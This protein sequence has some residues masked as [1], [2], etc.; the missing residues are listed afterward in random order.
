MSLHPDFI[1]E[2][3]RAT[4]SDLRTDSV[5]RKLYSTDASIYQIM[6][7]GVF[8]PKTHDELQAAVELAAKYKIPVLPRGSGSSLA[9]QAVGDA[10]I[11]DLSRY[12]DKIVDIDPEARNATAEPGVIL[13]DLNR[14]AAKFGLGFGPDPASADRATMGGVIAN[15]ATGAHSIRYGMAADHLLSADVI[16]ADG[17]LTTLGEV[18]LERASQIAH[19]LPR[20]KDF[21]PSEGLKPL[22]HG[23]GLPPANLEATLYSAALYIRKQYNQQIRTRWPQIWRNTSGYRLNYLLPWS[24]SRPPQWDEERYPNLDPSTFNLAPLLAGSEGTL[25]IMQRMTVNLVPLQREKILVVMPFESIADAVD[26][27]PAILEKKPSAIELLPRILIDLARDVPAY[28]PLIDFVDDDASD[29]LVVEFAGENSAHLRRQAENLG[30]NLRVVTDKMQQSNIWKVRKVG[31]GILSTSTSPTRGVTFIEDCAVPVEKL[32]DYVRGMERV[33]KHHNTTGVFYAHASAGC[34]HMRPVLNLQSAQGRGELRE[35]AEAALSLMLSLGGAMTG[36]HGD[37]LSRSEFLEKIYGEEINDAFRVLKLAADPE[38][39][40]NPGKIVSPPPMDENLRYG[41]SYAAQP[42]TVKPVLDFSAQGGLVNAI[43]QCNGAGVCRKFDGTMCPS[44]QATREESHSTR[45]RA[46]MLR[47]FISQAM[48]LR[49]SSSAEAI[50]KTERETA[51]QKNARSDVQEAVANSLDLCLACKGCQSECPS[52]VDMAKLKYEFFNDYYKK[53]LRKLRDYL[54]GYIG[55][56]AKIGAPFGWLVNLVLGNQA[57]GGWAKKVLRVS[58]HRKLPEF[59]KTPHSSLITPHASLTTEN[60][61]LNTVIY[62]PDPFS[63]YFEPE[64]EEAAL[65]VLRAAD[66]HVIKLPILGA[67]RTLISKS[68][69][70]AAKKHASKV[71]DEIAKVDPE[72]RYPVL[73]VEPSEIYT[74]KDEY[75]SFF[76]SDEKMKALAKRSWL[77][78]EFLLREKNDGENYLLRVAR[79]TRKEKEQNLANE[80]A[81]HNANAKSAQSVDKNERTK[82]LT[83]RENQKISLHGHCYQKARPPADDGLP[84]G[85]EATAEMLRR[86]GYEVDIIPSGCCGMAGSFGYEKEHYELSMQVGEL[87]LFPEI[88]KLEGEIPVVAPGTSCREQIEDGTGVAASH[89]LVLVANLLSQI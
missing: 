51:S 80:N 43:E 34:L 78:D 73:G 54:F 67:G 13:S 16:L 83:A 88:R 10:L 77:V 61:P 44:F 85:Q 6:P 68:F 71:R 23:G 25:A 62:L 21:S 22:L 20:S 8:I 65:K 87:I 2:L 37:G 55:T 5:T 36:E 27:V 89:P 45:G 24:P 69:L 76:P 31:L 18:S 4:S 28:A 63:H 32:G 64:I 40:L 9:G 19:D 48:S 35:I 15:N 41:E 74:L 26:A 7:K 57:I 49:G 50:Y 30:R 1:H 52:G 72:G 58:E 66:F 56:F 70:D 79:F 29:I 84:V 82:V 3:Q 38:N 11:L 14:A 75:L 53:H 33:F 46:N 81:T 86:F 60:R 42:F 12:L 17:A 39:L 59:K 47:V